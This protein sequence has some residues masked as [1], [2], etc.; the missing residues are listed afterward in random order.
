MSV[1]RLTVSELIRESKPDWEPVAKREKQATTEGYSGPFQVHMPGPY[2]WTLLGKPC[3]PES[4]DSQ[5][6]AQERQVMGLE[7]PLKMW[8]EETVDVDD[9]GQETRVVGKVGSQTPK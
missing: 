8:N 4:F 2:D 1:R 3:A 7:E 5:I 6:E 9:F